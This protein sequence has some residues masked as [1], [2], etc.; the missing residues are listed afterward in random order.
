M[1]L[2]QYKNANFCLCEK[3]EN[4]RISEHRDA[5]YQA[6]NWLILEEM[7]MIWGLA[8][9]VKFGQWE[10]A[11]SHHWERVVHMEGAAG[12]EARSREVDKSSNSANNDQ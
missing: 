4:A 5:E 12:T 7:E 3:R 10:F 11:Q 2:E 8:E 9:W 6:Q 1:W